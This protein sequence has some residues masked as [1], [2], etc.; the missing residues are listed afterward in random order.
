MFRLMIAWA[1]G[2]RE[3]RRGRNGRSEWAARPRKS[4]ECQIEESLLGA[5]VFLGGLFLLLSALL[6][7]A[8]LVLGVILFRRL[9]GKRHSRQGAERKGHAQHKRHQFLHVFSYEDDSEVRP[10]NPG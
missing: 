2:C 8:L 9:L 5:A 1:T 7:G 6:L 10:W 4:I 3:K